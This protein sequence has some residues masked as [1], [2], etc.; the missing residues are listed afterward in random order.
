MQT[1]ST[2]LASA[3]RVPSGPTPTISQSRATTGV[4]PALVPIC[5]G[6][7]RAGGLSAA[8]PPFVCRLL[9]VLL[10]TMPFK[11]AQLLLTA[12]PWGA[13]AAKIVG[14]EGLLGF[15]F[16]GTGALLAALGGGTD[17]CV[18]TCRC[19]LSL[20]AVCCAVTGTDAL[21]TSAKAPVGRFLLLPAFAVLLCELPCCR[22]I[23]AGDLTGA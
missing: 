17:L 11:A 22:S 2:H 3:L 16:F 5:W 4:S 13:G 9:P 7:L 1:R 10:A 18:M 8:G 6:A 12:W 21:T 14:N 15:C 20:C 23:A 19:F